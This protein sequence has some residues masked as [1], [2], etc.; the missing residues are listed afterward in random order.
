VF[1]VAKSQQTAYRHING[2]VR[3]SEA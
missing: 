1:Q 3:V 2:I